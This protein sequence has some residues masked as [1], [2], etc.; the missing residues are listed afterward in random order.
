MLTASALLSS[1]LLAQAQEA[2][3][4]EDGVDG[5]ELEQLGMDA[6]KELPVEQ[7][8]SIVSGFRDFSDRLKVRRRPPPA[9]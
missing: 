8:H 9:H 5:A 6:L 4:R 3:N 2:L 1:L 7:Q